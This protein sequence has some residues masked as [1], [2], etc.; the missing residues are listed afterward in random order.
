MPL[1]SALEKVVGDP[2]EAEDLAEKI[3]NAVYGALA[4]GIWD[5]V[6]SSHGKIIWGKKKSVNR[7]ATTPTALIADTTG[8][9]SNFP[10]AP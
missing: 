9:L 2:D 4:D 6:F 8:R 1:L 5:A 3:N 7:A 10:R